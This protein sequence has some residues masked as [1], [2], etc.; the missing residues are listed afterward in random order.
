[1]SSRSSRADRRRVALSTGAP[2]ST[3]RRS[4]WSAS[5]RRRPGLRGPIA[6]SEQ[7]DDFTPTRP[8]RWLL[9]RSDVR[10]TYEGRGGPDAD[11]PPARHR[12][13]RGQP[14]RLRRAPRRRLCLDRRDAA[15]HAGGISLSQ[16]ATRQEASARPET[17][18]RR[19][20]TSAR[21]ARLAGRA[22]RVRT[23]AFGV[24]VDPNISQPLP[25]AGLS[26]VDFDLFGTGAQFNGFFGGSYGQLAFSAPSLGGTRW[27]LAGRAF[28][29]ASSYNDRAFEG[30]REQYSLDIRQR[31]AQAAVWLL[32][33]LS[34][35]AALR[36]EYD[37]DY[38]RSARGDAKHRRRSSSRATR[39]RTR[40]AS[41]ST[42]SAP[43]GRRRSGAATRAA[44]AGGRGGSP[45]SDPST[46]HAT[47]LRALR[48]E[49]AAHRRRCRRA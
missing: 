22:S 25:F 49:P 38:T 21:R 26:Y 2:G 30:G 7:T 35:R 16:G 13:P 27:Q 8:G 28:G 42:C 41:G 47:D 24:I 36:I 37:W 29:I 15:G 39:T 40:F 31:P 17:R 11:P 33:P 43:D 1:M 23:L 34:A 44:S 3:R 48:R 20:Q 14:A 12:A 5:P 10:Q 19:R 18:R 4:A 32:R 9:A 46:A 6:G 45:G